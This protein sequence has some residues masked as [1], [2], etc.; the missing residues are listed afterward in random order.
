MNDTTSKKAVESPTGK[1]WKLP[2]LLL[3]PQGPSYTTDHSMQ[4]RFGSVSSRRTKPYLLGEVDYALVG[5]TTF[6]YIP[7]FLSSFMQ[8]GVA[9]EDGEVQPI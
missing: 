1:G 9:V 7:P 3:E 6:C 8:L 2:W 4:L 5:G